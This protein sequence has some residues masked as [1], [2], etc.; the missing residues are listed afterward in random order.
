MA[1]RGSYPQDETV[2]PTHELVTQTCVSNANI[3]LVRQP[4]EGETLRQPPINLH[5]RAYPH[6]AGREFCGTSARGVPLPIKTQRLDPPPPAGPPT[7]KKV[8]H[9]DN[10]SKQQ[11]LRRERLL[12]RVQGLAGSPGRV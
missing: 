3:I 5:S 6:L 4:Y 12:G 1:Y 8:V 9:F 11:R 10:D 2:L 7:H